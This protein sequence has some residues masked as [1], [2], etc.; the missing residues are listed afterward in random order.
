MQAHWAKNDAKTKYV[1]TLSMD[2]TGAQLFNHFS[3][4]RN[5]NKPHRYTLAHATAF[6]SFQY[7]R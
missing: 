7:I 6:A 5:L 3:N 2:F 4:R 1:E